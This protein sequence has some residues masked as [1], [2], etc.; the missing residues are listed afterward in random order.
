VPDDERIED[1][2]CHLSGLIH[3]TPDVGMI[4]GSG[5]GELAD[6][7]REPVIVP[8]T[9]VP[10]FPRDLIPGHR[11]EIRF[12]R[13]RGKRVL[14]FSG[15]FHYYQGYS[16]ADVVLPVRLAARLGTPVMIIT[17]A[18]GGIRD[19]LDR[20]DIMLISDHINL[21]GDNPLRGASA[22]SFSTPFVDMTEPYDRRLLERVHGCAAGISD[23][24]ALKE[25]VYVGVAGP[26]YETA[27]EIRFMKKI[28]GD[29]V[30]MSTV[31]E[32]IACRQE[33]VRVLG[34]SAIVNKAAGQG[35]ATAGPEKLS[36]EDVVKSAAETGRRLAVL[37]DGILQEVVE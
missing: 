36:H 14:L 2:L 4:L 16:M 6:S 13:M 8:F 20:G 17:N 27:A 22:A 10:G 18:A 29:A 23:M 12:G 33:K 31:P 34:I 35:D 30:G 26:S 3:D 37:I 24:G 1:A 28:G 11:G 5:L 15:R 21:M 7:V 25:G 19:D 32:V 9:D